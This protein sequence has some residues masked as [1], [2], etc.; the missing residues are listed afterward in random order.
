MFYRWRHKAQTSALISRL[1]RKILCFCWPMSL[2]ELNVCW[3]TFSLGSSWKSVRMPENRGDQA[4]TTGNEHSLLLSGLAGLISQET[5][6]GE[7]PCKFMQRERK[8]LKLEA[9]K[10]SVTKS[11][12]S[13]QMSISVEGAHDN[14]PFFLLQTNGIPCPSS[15]PN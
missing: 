4:F 7:G 2:D 15:K 13:G 9:G 12:E 8:C 6:W 1:P 11:R 3:S 10:Y 14:S 5:T